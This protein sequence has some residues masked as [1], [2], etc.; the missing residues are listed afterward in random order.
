MQSNAITF[1]NAMFDQSAREAIDFSGQSFIS[2]DF[3]VFD[4]SNVLWTCFSTMI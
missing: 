4:K 3:F 1:P 2:S